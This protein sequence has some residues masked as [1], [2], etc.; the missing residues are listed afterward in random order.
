MVTQWLRA[1]LWNHED[2]SW[3]SS[4][5]VTSW[6]PHKYLWPQLQAGHRQ[7]DHQGLLASSSL[8]EK[9]QASGLGKSHCLPQKKRQTVTPNGFFWRLHMCTG[10]KVHA[11]IY[12][13]TD[14]CSHK[15]LHKIIKF[16]LQLGVGAH[17]C[18]P[19]TW[20]VKARVLGQYELRV[21]SYLKNNN[22]FQSP[23]WWNM[24]FNPAL[25]RQ[26]LENQELRPTLQSKLQSSL[27][28]NVRPY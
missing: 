27:A 23:V 8:A 13:H 24:Y 26:R 17:T 15:Y 5:K 20:E 1:L 22:R 16:H 10:T 18:N 9:A 28:Y 25:G 6:L 11:S 14:K 19:I 12:T 21:K 4:T 7:E 3:D 2:W